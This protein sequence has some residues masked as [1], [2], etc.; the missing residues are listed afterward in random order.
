MGTGLDINLKPRLRAGLFVGEKFALHQTHARYIVCMMW[1]YIAVDE[2]VIFLARK[3]SQFSYRWDCDVFPT[4]EV[5][6]VVSG[7]NTGCG[8][9]CLD[10]GLVKQQL[11][12]SIS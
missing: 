9:Y 2:N 5:F 3:Y 11:K 4:P 7:N 12:R 8:A 10:S 1:S 6:T